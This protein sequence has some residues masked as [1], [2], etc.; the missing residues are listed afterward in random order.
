MKKTAVIFPG[1]GYHTDKPL[2][3]Y[4]RKIAAAQGYDVI[5][6]PY[7]KFPKGVKGSKEKM[8]K[9]FF[10]ALEQA[11]QILRDVDFS[12][13]DDILFI[14]K[15][16][17][18]AVAAAYAEKYV[19]HTRNVYYTPVEPSFQFMKQPGIVFTGTEDPWVTFDAV[20]QGCWE[21]RF[22]LYVTED[23]NHSLETGDVRRDLENLQK[24]M[25]I[26]EEYIRSGQRV[27]EKA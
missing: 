14:S 15:S 13:N 17:G 23:G 1:I 25:G 6:V 7:G 5:E 26:T 24:I 10:S 19:L 16:V 3:Y 4:S 22:P 27:T 2:L 8:E 18:T 11:E 20:E 12:E 21:G 9:S